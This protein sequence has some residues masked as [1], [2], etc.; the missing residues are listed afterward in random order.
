MIVPASLACPPAALLLQRAS[1]GASA[2]AVTRPAASCTNM[3]IRGHFPTQRHTVAA[4]HTAQAEPA[5]STKDSPQM[6]KAYGVALVSLLAGAAFVHNIYQ[7]DLVRSAG[8]A[9]E[10][11]RAGCSHQQADPGGRLTLPLQR[12]PVQQPEKDAVEQ[13]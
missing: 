4:L 1:A 12:L 2:A 7:P 13:Q 10:L 11:R 5:S 9:A 6:L 8:F 3:Q